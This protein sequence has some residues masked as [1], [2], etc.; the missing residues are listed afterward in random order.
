MW[1]NSPRPLGV[2]YLKKHG[3][4]G[5]EVVIVKRRKIK[6]ISIHPHVEYPAVILF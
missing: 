6:P 2:C 1:I 3:E 5:D 4:S